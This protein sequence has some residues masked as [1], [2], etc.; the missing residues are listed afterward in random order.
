MKSATQ[1]TTILAEIDP[2]KLPELRDRLTLIGQRTDDNP[3]FRPRELPDTHFM[4]FVLVE[5]APGELRPL[6][7]W[8]TNHDG[9]PADYLARV[10]RT[11]PAID[12]VLDCC[13]AY[14][15]TAAG[16]DWIAWMT[17]RAYRSAAFYAAYRGIPRRRVLDDAQ[18][19]A[20]L[21]TIA[22]DPATRAALR[23]ER[24]ATASARHAYLAARVAAAAPTLDTEPRADAAVRWTTRRAIVQLGIPAAVGLLVLLG[25]LVGLAGLVPVLVGV[26]AVLLAGGAAIGLAIAHLQH[27]ERT[28][29]P[30][31]TSAPVHDTHALHLEED[32]YAQNQLTHLVY[33]KP[34]WF[35]LVVCYLVLTVIDIAARFYFVLGDLNGITSIHFARWVIVRDRRDIAAIP[36]GQARRHRLLFFSNYDGSWESYL[37]EF[38]D[39][40]SSGLTAIW[41]NTVLFPRTTNLT[42]AGAG[43]GARNEEA[44]KQWTRDHQIAT[45]VWWTGIPRSTVQNVR[46][47][48]ALRQQLRVTLTETEAQVWLH[49]V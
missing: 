35:R 19:H 26:A 16:P 18:L 8:E 20:A 39:R 13:L 25:A 11:T 49:K 44:F 1:A 46:D 28:D 9:A 48:V 42:G 30:I 23:E 22:D 43:D 17:A 2:A 41:S 29:V 15:G 47:D 31:D 27:L 21:Q 32:Y 45:Q 24:H 38:V 10:A 3:L 33:L 40:S 34:G 5:D 36:P 37:G 4:R 6:L 7:A 12:N 14:P